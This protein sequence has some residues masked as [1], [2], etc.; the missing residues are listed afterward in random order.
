MVKNG[1]ILFIWDRY[2]NFTIKISNLILSLLY[3]ADFV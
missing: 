3:Y 1:Q 2:S